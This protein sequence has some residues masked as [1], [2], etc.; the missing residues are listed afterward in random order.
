MTITIGNHE[1]LLVVDVQRDFMPGGALAVPDGD[2]VVPA[3]NRYAA[4]ARRKGL[5]VF[6]SRDWH[7]KN[8]CSFRARGGPWPQHC[9]AGTPGAAFAE[10]LDLAPDTV[11]ID[12]AMREDADAYSA[13]SGT[14]LAQL[15]RER[16]AKRLLV[17][18][19]ATDYCVLNT[20]R[21]ALKEG[22]GVLLLKDAIRAV[23]VQPGDGER[24][25]REM[26]EAG[27]V[28]VNYQELSS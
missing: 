19:L 15:L 2:A 27:A 7:P 17:G 24:A 1:A 14:P 10:N 8:H 25:Q 13:F 21:D 5:P 12:K 9:V 23:N 16:G 28:A 4:L 20:V 11:V 26:Q 6:A 3:L 22:F 18:G